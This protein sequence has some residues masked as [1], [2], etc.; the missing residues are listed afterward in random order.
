[1]YKKLEASQLECETKFKNGIEKYRIKVEEMITK[2]CEHYQA[3]LDTRDK[4]IAECK[5]LEDQRDTE[6]ERM[7]EDM[8][9]VSV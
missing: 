3:C 2:I 6:K 8:K 9:E 5:K 4:K 7:D 1:V